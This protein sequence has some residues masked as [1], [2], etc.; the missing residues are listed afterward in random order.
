MLYPTFAYKDKNEGEGL[1]ATAVGKINKYTHDVFKRDV[2]HNLYHEI[3]RTIKEHKTCSQK[4][5]FVK[6]KHNKIVYFP[7]QFHVIGKNN[8]YN[9]LKML[10]KSDR[11]NCNY[12][13]VLFPINDLCYKT[14]I[15]HYQLKNDEDDEIILDEYYNNKNIFNNNNIDISKNE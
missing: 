4:C 13:S 11:K 15:K 6:D 2:Y 9:P 1:I 10:H 8:C 3:H 14:Y 12:I 5:F 7:V